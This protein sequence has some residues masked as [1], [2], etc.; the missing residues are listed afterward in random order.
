[1][2][3]LF[4][5]NKS[6]YPPKEG[7]PMAMDANIQG[8]LNSGHKVKVLAM[9]T[10]KYFIN[11][12]DIPENYKRETGIEFIYNDL[13]IKPLD[14]FV[15]LLSNK[16]YHVERFI[17][18]DFENK[19]I[20]ILNKE[21][22]DI[23]QLEMLYMTPY[24]DIIRKY[25]SAKIVL[26]SHNIEHLIWD[27]ITK[28]TGNPIKRAYLG[29]LTKK[30][31]KY[32]ISTLGLYDGIVTISNNDADFFRSHES[33]TPIIDVP[34][35]V[36]ISNYQQQNQD[37]EFP[38]LFHLGSMNWVP[39]EEGIKWFLD[40]AWPEIHKKYPEVKFN[41]A[42]RMMPEWLTHLNMPNVEV[43][44]EVPDAREF[45]NSKAVM[46]VPLLSGSGLRIKIIE[47]MAMG[48]AI[49][50]TTIGAEGIDYTNG[51]SIL[52]A[53]THIEFLKAVERCFADKEYCSQ[54]GKN[55]RK[56]IEEKYSLERV[57]K[58]LLAFYQKVLEN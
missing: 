44:G 28:T 46:I 24:V 26:R 13:S 17:S 21:D 18:K 40:F 42:G 4:L 53:D 41:L 27:R 31:K 37:F 2:K 39:N 23:V 14:A 3:I 50:S 25:S 1:M 7:G 8:L 58:K 12:A 57:I 35:G 6:P 55:A 32:E 5:C 20:E 43:I 10:N 19:V 51:E 34:F 36:D 22:Y 49:I 9:N 56:L 29:S 16:S 45:I 54:L 33:G 47:G 30:L 48:N 15:N 52:I 38:S 11:P